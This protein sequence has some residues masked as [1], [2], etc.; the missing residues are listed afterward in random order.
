MGGREGEKLIWGDSEL[1]WCDFEVGIELVSRLNVTIPSPGDE[2][3]EP[4]DE[5][6][7]PWPPEN[8]CLTPEDGENPLEEYEEHQSC[9]QRWWPGRGN[10]WGRGG[11]SNRES[12]F[13]PP[14]DEDPLP[15]H[16]EHHCH[17]EHGGH[18]PWGP[19]NDNPPRWGHCP[20]RGQDPTPPPPDHNCPP[21]K[22]GDHYRPGDAQPPRRCHKKG[23]HPPCPPEH[24]PPPGGGCQRKPGEDH[25]PERELPLPRDECCPP[26][27]G[28]PSPPWRDRL[29]PCQ[30]PPSEGG[31]E[32]P[33]PKKCHRG[34]PEYPPCRS[35]HDCPS[36]GE[37]KEC[38]YPGPGCGRKGH[39]KRPGGEHPP[40]RNRPPPK[41]GRPGRGCPPL[42]G[43][44]KPEHGCPPPPPS[45]HRKPC[46]LLPPQGPKE[47]GR[48]PPYHRPGYP[49]SRMAI[50]S[51]WEWIRSA[52]W[53]IWPPVF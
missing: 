15:G 17:W 43:K 14:E 39:C 23:G 19:R 2:G 29:P 52:T 51:R 36:P 10:L 37:R 35:L 4:P 7:P 28:P 12:P 45:G 11:L 31:G 42:P 25:P 47:P 44:G 26:G 5:G 13:Q 24:S 27:D 49:S 8:E 21:P 50:E 30:G 48:G 38:P 33:P 1:V 20:P 6:H 32:Y 46:P 9:R 3:L 22:R 53:V 18:P 34:A 41:K 16:R 40:R